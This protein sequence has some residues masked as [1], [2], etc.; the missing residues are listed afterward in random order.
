MGFNASTSD[1]KIIEWRKYNSHMLAR[2]RPQLAKRGH[3]LKA[4]QNRYSKTNRDSKESRNRTFENRISKQHW[5]RDKEGH[6]IMTERSTEEE[7]NEN[8]YTQHRAPHIKTML[9]A[10]AE[11]NNIT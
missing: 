3:N 6:Y 1:Y 2:Q 4:K 8:I 7:N 5:K 10:Q 11:I 9:L